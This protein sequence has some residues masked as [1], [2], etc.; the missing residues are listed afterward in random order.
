MNLGCIWLLR[1]MQKYDKDNT[2]FFEYTYIHKMF[3]ILSQKT[4]QN[5][6][7]G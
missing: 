3:E 7:L 1:L 4:L 6:Q 2:Y 5:I